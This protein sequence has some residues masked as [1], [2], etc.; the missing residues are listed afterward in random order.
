MNR[1]R[2]DTERTTGEVIMQ[3]TGMTKRFG[4]VVALDNVDL[5]VRRG[6]IRGL[7][8]EN[9]SGK[10][11]ITSIFSGIQPCDSGQ[12]IYKG[13]KWAPRSMN[14]ALTQGVG[15]IV[16]ENGTVPGITVAE[17]MFL[18]EAG[19]FAKGGFVHGAAMR[20]AA[21]KALDDIGAGYLR[22]GA[23]TASL[24]MMDRKLVEV[25][26]VWMQHPELIVVDETTTSLSQKGREII[27]DLMER[28]KRSN[29]SIVFISHDLDEIM[30]K[31]DTLTV[32]RDGHIIRTF[33][34]SEFD[35]DAIR[36]SMIGR[37]LQGDYY[38]SDYDGSCSDE[39]V[40]E[41]KHVTLGDHVI[42]MDLQAHKGEILGIGGLSHCGMHTLGKVLY[43]ALKPERGEVLVHG[44]RVRDPAFAMKNKMG[45]AAKD[46]DVESLCI[47]ASIRDNI[48]IAGM[49]EFAIAKY[50]ILSSRERKY[51]QKQVDFMK[52]K[53]FSIDQPVSQ[54]SGGNKQKVVLGK[55]IGCGSD[56]LILDCPT[57]GIDI[58]VK[59]TMYQLMY[60]M[61]QEGKTIIMISEEMAE[62]MGMADRLLIMK[63]GRITKE[64]PRSAD[65]SDADIIKYMV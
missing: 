55:W 4:P 11:T 20:Q 8:G 30:E 33:E 35:A 28:M 22:A 44:K 41:M 62:L 50:L 52:I 32:L 19:R 37:E 27:Y 23:V 24:D 26:K 60:K 6:E 38:R 51:V 34:K 49:D 64:F 17:N 13:K 65:L 47:S 63:D 61:K 18:C 9:G 2:V 1:E 53:C 56:I 3:I 5:S 57:R 58:G 36:T 21:Q 48:S 40:L 39:V 10:S 14:W 46:R 31:C 45:Y 42:D 59:Q 43:G 16:Q 25:A 12:M 7:I 15:M 29:R 54:L